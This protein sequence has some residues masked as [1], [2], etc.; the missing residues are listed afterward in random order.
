MLAVSIL[1]GDRLI[2]HDP[3]RCVS[4]ET[5]SFIGC[6][7]WHLVYCPL[8]LSLD[9]SRDD[10]ARH[11]AFVAL[12]RAGRM[13]S[14]TVSRSEFDQWSLQSLRVSVDWLHRR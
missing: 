13:E 9:A 11:A 2:G 5:I 14:T 4:I 1:I 10:R 12:N 7:L 6:M 8:L 3:Y